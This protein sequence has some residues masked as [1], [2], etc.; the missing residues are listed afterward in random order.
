M[1]AVREA[2]KEATSAGAAVV[3]IEQQAAMYYR[4]SKL[5][6]D[7]GYSRPDIEAAKAS[8]RVRHYKRGDGGQ[9]VMISLTDLESFIERETI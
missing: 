5:M 8:G 7:F 3:I 2:I 9:A 6:S 1:S 4:Q